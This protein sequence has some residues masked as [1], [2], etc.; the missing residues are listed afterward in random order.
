MRGPI[1]LLKNVREAPPLPPLN[2]NEPHIINVDPLWLRPALERPPQHN[3]EVFFMQTDTTYTSIGKGH[4]II[5]VHGVTQGGHSVWINTHDF[6]PNFFVK[7]NPATTPKEL[8][9]ALEKKISSKLY[10]D[11]FIGKREKYVEYWEVAP[12]GTCSILEYENASENDVFIQVFMNHPKQVPI[13]RELLESG[14]LGGKHLRCPETF[15]ANIEYT[16]RFMVDTDIAGCQWIRAKNIRIPNEFSRRSRAQIEINLVAGDLKSEKRDEIAPLRIM[17]Y[18][19]ECTTCDGTRRFPDATRDPIINLCAHVEQE[20]FPTLQVAFC[21]V[22]R[23]GDKVSPLDGIEVHE[24][25]DERAMLLSF[26]EFIRVVDPDIITGYNIHGFDCVYLSNRCKAL[27]I[28]PIDISRLPNRHCESRATSFKNRAVGTKESFLM[29]ITGRITFDLYQWMQREKKLPFYGLNYVAEKFLGDKKEDVPYHMIDSL[30]KGS[31]EDRARVAKYCHKDAKL[32]L[33][34]MANQRIIILTAEMCRVTGVSFKDLLEHGQQHKTVCLILRNIRKEL[35]LFPTKSPP[36]TPFT[37][38]VVITPIKAFYEVP[39]ATI[40]FASL[41]PSIMSA[42]NL[43]YSTYL[44]MERAK[45]RNLSEDKYTV[46]PDSNGEYCFVKSHVKKGILPK[47]LEGLLERRAIAKKDMSAAFKAGN[48]NLGN[49]MDGRQL[50]LKICA[51]SVYGFT[52]ADKL[53]LTKIAKSVTGFGR[54]LLKLTKHEI[55]AR[56]TKDTPD[57]ER[58]LRECIDPNWD[59]APDINPIPC[60]EGNALIVYGDSVTGDTPVLLKSP[61]NN[62]VIQTISSLSKTWEDYPHFKPNDTDRFEKE[63]A[64]LQGWM[65]WTYDRTLQNGQGK[66]TNIKRVIRHKTIKKIYRVLTHTGCVDVTEDHS[67]LDPKCNIVKPGDCC[68]GTELLHASIDHIHS[69][70]KYINDPILY[71]TQDKLEAA[72]NFYL[73][74][75]FGKAC[76]L[77]IQEDYFIIR[78]LDDTP[79]NPRAIKKI[80]PISTSTTEEFV[81]DIETEEGYF[82]AGIGEMIVKNT[83]SV[84]IRFCKETNIG[85]ARAIALA[86]EASAYMQPFY[87]KPL[88]CPFEKVYCPYLLEDK[89]RYAG[90]YWTKPEQYDKIDYKGIELVRRDWTKVCRETMAAVSEQLLLHKNRDECI[91]IVHRVCTELLNGKIDISKLVLTKGFTKTLEEYAANSKSVPAHIQVV[92]NAI[93]RDPAT[94]PTVG[95]R[96][97]YVMVEGHSSLKKSECAEDPLYVMDNDIPI[98][99]FYY[100][101]KQLKGPLIRFLQPALC[102]DDIERQDVDG[103]YAKNPYKT[104]A[105]KLLFEGPHMKRRIQTIRKAGPGKITAFITKLPRCFECHAV[106]KKRHDGTYEPTCGK[107]ECKEITHYDEYKDAVDVAEKNMR[108]CQEICVKCQKGMPYEDIL[109]ENKICDNWYQRFNAKKIF[110]T[111]QK[112]LNRFDF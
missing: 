88:R 21:L 61:D 15:E 65:I 16:M 89:K 26:L 67:L 57:L 8:M 60:Y 10:F 110:E 25:H 109:C 108:D 98:D 12:K 40:D 33:D 35:M 7:C 107:P 75:S 44:S 85:V 36:R 9:K 79:E 76:S 103:F 100:I 74:K 31:P 95:D 87:K 39:I 51:N 48:N 82:Q 20:G 86:K 2:L 73:F 84:M 45:Q 104:T 101:E 38:A 17:S 93:A 64:Q 30:Y 70:R 58:C 97:S 72:K 18:D 59:D 4:A 54:D 56:F 27:K 22:P 37:G 69:N 62:I 68:V 42:H 23:E 5:E 102:T 43:C 112:K 49:I 34:I 6:L 13:A 105:H 28:H 19:I 83:D 99:A 1:D 96:V 111:E 77:D 94:A 90:V 78:L 41:Y 92:K 91:K 66:W 11:E 53:P 81:Y 47:I 63:Q 14:R 50:S 106:A 32:P 55:E 80:E 46:P 71:A 24:F 29:T 3:G 52:S